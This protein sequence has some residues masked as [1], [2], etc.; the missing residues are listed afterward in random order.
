MRC[1]NYRDMVLGAV[2]AIVISLPSFILSGVFS[3]QPYHS[4]EIVTEGFI[5]DGLKYLVVANFVKNDDCVFKSLVAYGSSIGRYEVLEWED[6]GVDQGDR[7]AGAQTL[8][9][10]ID[11]QGNTY[12]YLELR[13]RHTCSGKR[14]DRTFAQFPIM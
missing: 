10:L 4:V 1:R 3:P 12:D 13:T 14:V 8:T 5:E 2:I 11:T 7:I 6:P 9:V